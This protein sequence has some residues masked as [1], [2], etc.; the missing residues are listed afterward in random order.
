MPPQIEARNL[1][2]LGEFADGYR[3][4][5]F[6]LVE[7]KDGSF[8]LRDAAAGPQAEETRVVATVRTS[9][10]VPN[11]ERPEVELKTTKMT[12]AMGKDYDALFWTESSIEK[13][14]IPYYCHMRTLTETDMAAIAEICRNPKL[15]AIGHVPPSEPE[16]LTDP[17]DWIHLFLADSANPMSLRAFLQLR[18]QPSK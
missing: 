16:I 1:R 12:K 17:A 10:K 9:S 4:K 2:A 6:S 3:D 5:D 8:R 14:L 13:F 15:V 11:R 18:V 7:M